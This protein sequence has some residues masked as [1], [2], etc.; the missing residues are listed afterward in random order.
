MNKGTYRLA[1]VH[2]VFPGLDGKVRKVNIRYKNL[3]NDGNTTNYKGA[4]DV[5]V[6]RAIQRLALLVPS[7][8]KTAD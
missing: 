2:Q 5:I 6:S 3:G 1:Q 7:D 4:K 8:Q